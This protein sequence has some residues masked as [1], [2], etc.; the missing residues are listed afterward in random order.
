MTHARRRP[1]V[2]PRTPL[3]PRSARRRALALLA[4]AAL[5]LSGA[6]TAGAEGPDGP[7]AAAAPT[8]AF[9]TVSVPGSHNTAMGCPGDWQPGCAAAELAERP[10]GVWEGTFAL[11]P[12]DYEYKVAFDG[13]WDGALGLGGDPAG[14]NVAYTVPGAPGGAPVDVTFY[15]DPVSGD[16]Q[17]TAQGPVV[18]LPGS[19]QAA[20][21][22][23]GDW[24]PD[25]LATW[26]KDPDGDGVYEWSTTQI[27]AGSYQV[28]V[29]HGMSWDVNYGQG[30]A[31][32]GDNYTFATSDGEQVAFAYDVATHLLEITVENPPLTGVGQQR[33]HWVRADL[34]AWPADLLGGADPAEL[35]WALHHAPD[36]GLGV[37]DGAVTG[38]AGAGE[39]PLTRDPAGLPADVLADFPALAGS[40]AL[41]LDPGAD[42]GALLTGEVQV[43][44][45]GADGLTALTGV[46]TP[47]ALDDLYAAAADA[48]LGVAWSG[49]APTFRLWAPTAQE[50]TLLTWAPGADTSTTPTR[51]A[52]DRAADGTWSATGDPSWAGVRY[53]Y[54]VEVYVPSTGRVE[55]NVVTDPYA[56]ALTLNSTHAVAVDLADPAYRPALWADTAQPVVERAVDHT[57][58]ELH[59]RDFSI[60]DETVPE[61]ERGTYLAFARESDGTARL[62]ELADAGLT[63]VHLLPTFDIASIEE[64]RA[65][66]ATTPDLSGFGP[67]AE[68]QQ[69]AV[70]AIRERDGF[71]WGYDPWHF[72]APEGSYA[73]DPEGGARVAEFRTMVGA[74]HEMGLGVVLDQVF[75]HTA[76]SG[77]DARSVLDRVV[78]GYYHRL[79]GT[80]QVQT[81]TCCQNVATEHAMAEKLMVDSVVT[82]ARD[83]KVDGFRFDLMGHHSKQNMLAVREALDALTV[84]A[85]GVDGSAVY[86][87]GEG[88]D[89]GEVAG[90]ALFEQA[91]QGQLG[92]TGIGTFS[93]RL[94]DAVHGGSPVEGSSMFTQGFGTGLATD[95]NGQPAQLGDA[96]TVNTGSATEYADLGLATDVVRL[97]LAGNLRD[98]ELTT[99]TGEVRRGDEV[100]YRGA[101]AGYADSPEEVVTY[102][103]AHDNETLFDLLTIKLPQSTSMA[104]RVRMNTLSQATAALAQTVTFWH[105]GTDQLRSK[106]LDRDSYDSGDWFNAI[107][108]TGQDNGFGRGLPGAWANAE[109]WPQMRPLLEDAALKPTAADI[110]TARAAADDLLRLRFSTPLFRLGDADLIRQKLTF[111]DAGAGATPGVI[112]MHVDDKA[113][114]DVD[115]DLDGLLVVFNASPDAVTQELPGLAGAAYALSPVQAAGA[116]DVVRTTTWDAATGTVTVPARTV[117]VLVQPQ[118]AT[119]P[120][121]PGTPGTPGTPGD[122]GTPGGGGDPAGGTDGDPAAAGP[123]AGGGTGGAL[124]VTGAHVLL[125]L[126]GALAALVGGTLLVRARSRARAAAER[127]GVVDRLP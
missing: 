65:A 25:C 3:E 58:Y 124:A 19:Y 9:A 75:N 50:V 81:S 69:A 71:N 59:V 104:D 116:D 98:Y 125:G 16:F 5:L 86:L 108:W 38:P 97:G 67:A 60:A 117:A 53:Q 114:P 57:I 40:V 110:A 47:G 61:A 42:P 74:L 83:Y 14:A 46:Q 15:W 63:T 87:Y 2:A 35:T 37:T 34:L 30:G 122:P 62:R 103:D 68:D 78:P 43:S 44:Q 73:T 80:G 28:K 12:G 99:H 111:P 54:E 101:P 72:T 23:P 100:D 76:A 66:Q 45:A 88:W 121:D 106:S 31:M 105:A 13:G 90:N 102:V 112:V 107:D 96:A 92:G 82:W 39:V 93:D 33:A 48:D 89:F 22:C 18:T 84:E 11:P 115:A 52:T 32:G 120:V 94:R 36:G 27:P 56:V 79:D 127:V 119:G 20:A 123:G 24:A 26:A 70:G 51:V 113:G 126:L 29:A 118:D 1:S 8:A 41:R 64:D 109:K 7:E 95:P 21:G 6:T 10:D 77:Q 85:D 91:T 49:G 55:T 4:A 17:N